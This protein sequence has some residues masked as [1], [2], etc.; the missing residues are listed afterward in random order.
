MPEIHAPYDLRDQNLK[1]LGVK[2]SEEKL[3]T[4]KVSKES[5]Q[6]LINIMGNMNYDIFPRLTLWLGHEIKLYERDVWVALE[7][8]I[9]NNLKFFSD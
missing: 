7:G 3:A 5:V 4:G 1:D 9:R 6:E 8:H 2:I